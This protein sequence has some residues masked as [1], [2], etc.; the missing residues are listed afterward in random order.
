M[1]SLTIECTIRLLEDFHIGTGNGNIGLYDDGQQK[2]KNG[3]PTISASTVKGLLRDSCRTLD[4]M[5]KLLDLPYD[6]FVF[7]RLFESFDN[8]SS[9]DIE[10]NPL[11]DDNTPPEHAIIHY[12]TAVEH[13]KRKAKKNSLRS[14]EFGSKGMQYQL[15]INYLNRFDDSM[16]ISQ[17]LVEGLK[18][19]KCLGGHRRR[20]FGAVEIQCKG[21]VIQDLA[22]SPQE[23]KPGNVLRIMFELAEDTVISSKAQA[24]NLLFT[25]DYIPGT[26]ILGMFRSAMLS[27]KTQ[28]DYLDED[29]VSADFFYPLPTGNA[30]LDVE[31]VPAFMSFRKK[32]EYLTAMSFQE[33]DPLR[34]LPS[35]ALVS[36]KTDKFAEMISKNVLDDEDSKDQGK[37]I[38]EGYLCKAGKGSWEDSRYYKVPKL[39]Y[40]RNYID[41]SKQ[42][43]SQNGIFVEERLQKGTCFLGSISFATDKDCT[44]FLTE[45]GD[46]LRG[47][48]PLHIGR[49]GK[50]MYVKEYRR[51]TKSPI[52]ELKLEAGKPFTITLLTDAIVYSEKL[53]ACKSLNSE[54]LAA[55]LGD[56]FKSDDFELMAYISRHG[57]VS[58]FSGTSGLRKFRDFA[59]RKGSCFKFRYLGDSL[60]D[61]QTRL[62][63]LTG[64]GIGFKRKEGFGR[65]AINHPLYEISRSEIMGHCPNLYNGQLD[66]KLTSKA[67]SF[68]KANSIEKELS[69]FT[70]EKWRSMV[71]DTLVSIESGISLKIIEERF[72][73]KMDSNTDGAWGA[74]DWRSQ[75]ANLLIKHINDKV[76]P[77]IISTALK[78]LLARRGGK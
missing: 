16:A 29:K 60:T 51:E 40:Q 36:A 77:K 72:R 37:G 14:V 59:I 57:V 30:S 20:G 69:S 48:I 2:D 41:R 52:P 11:L 4:E 73:A 31:I 32:K 53:E 46:W 55:L 70:K 76:D 56:G 13:S 68:E 28:S 8:L 74:K 9:L 25:N 38:Y 18:N 23:E 42:S 24:G 49:G 27:Q 5:K 7:S 65:I 64:R 3:E 1:Q 17:Y 63:E 58:S 26:T 35:W 71:A 47:A 39:Y 61:L 34:R 78:L 66:D 54:I 6:K 22:S 75:I 50:A 67:N 19:I 43:T 10:V 62:T 12:F 21:P 15:I 44:Q 33:S 45:F